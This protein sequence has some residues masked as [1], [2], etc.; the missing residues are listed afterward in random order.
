[1]FRRVLSLLVALLLLAPPAW[2][3]DAQGWYMVL[4]PGGW[5]CQEAVQ[6]EANDAGI[7]AMLLNA[8]KWIM[9]HVPVVELLT[10]G[11]RTDFLSVG[12]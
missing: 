4:G 5:S 3:T 2:A 7:Y 1:M 9:R 11:P 6:R 8:S 10:P 12:V